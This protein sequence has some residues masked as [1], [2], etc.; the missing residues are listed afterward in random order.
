MII[1][2]IIKKKKLQATKL[3]D[4]SHDCIQMS[5]IIYSHNEMNK[6]CL[7]WENL[8]LSKS[9]KG[10]KEP[11]I[12]FNVSISQKQLSDLMFIGTGTCFWP[13]YN[14]PDQNLFSFGFL[15]LPMSPPLLLGSSRA[16]Y[17]YLKRNIIITTISLVLTVFQGVS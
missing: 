4:R 2:C 16:P 8:S 9:N 14:L 5:D 15:C 12:R 7:Q 6:S 17:L 13:T 10:L 3:S 11:E 1:T